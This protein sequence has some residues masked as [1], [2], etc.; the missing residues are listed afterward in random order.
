MRRRITP[1]YAAWQGMKQRCLN[2]LNPGYKNYGGRGI[3][4]CDRWIN[5]FE[6]FVSDLGEK[7]HGAYLD[8]VNNDGDYEP[9]NVRW[10]DSFTNSRNRR[11]SKDPALW[12]RVPQETL[13]GIA[14]ALA[15]G[16]DRAAFI[17]NAIDRELR[18]RRKA[19]S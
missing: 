9:S 4:I 6:N 2:P 12:F 18:R 11:R 3:K 13:D 15:G 8:R 14:A 16:E 17:R 1:T 7:P 19:G 10:A 5:S